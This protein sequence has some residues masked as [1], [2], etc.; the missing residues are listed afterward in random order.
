MGS[1][2]RRNALGRVE[3]C[4]R[5]GDG[6]RA[7]RHKTAQ[8]GASAGALEHAQQ[9]RGHG[10]GLRVA[11]PV[12]R[13]AGG[14]ARRAQR[15]VQCERHRLAL[16]GARQDAPKVRE[17]C[18]RE[19]LGP[20]AHCG[21]ALDARCGLALA[22]ALDVYKARIKQRGRQHAIEVLEPALALATLL[23]R[24]ARA[25]RGRAD[26]VAA[27]AVLAARRGVWRPSLDPGG[28]APKGRSKG[29][30]VRVK[31]ARVC[32]AARSRKERAA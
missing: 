20:A 3:E 18:G 9:Q 24:Q 10:L 12:R 32:A 15:R 6:A 7:G 4:R 28:P 21:T 17:H 23:G 8:Q 13:P 25:R 22:A 26:R 31:L 11:F 1:A 19:H 2:S 30:R 16:R 27:R 29:G 14:K 5:C